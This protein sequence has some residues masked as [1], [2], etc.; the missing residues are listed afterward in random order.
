MAQK[1]KE[2][3]FE[4][5]SVVPEMGVASVPRALIKYARKTG[6]GT[7]TGRPPRFSIFSLFFLVESGG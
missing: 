1:T 7:A 5:K 2:E 4:A 6:G 3:N